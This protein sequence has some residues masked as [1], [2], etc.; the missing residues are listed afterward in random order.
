MSNNVYTPRDT[1]RQSTPLPEE[2]EYILQ[3]ISVND[4]P[5]D[6]LTF[7]PNDPIHSIAPTS[8]VPPDTS[9][10]TPV[11][12]QSNPANPEQFRIDFSLLPA[13]SSI[14]C[15]K[16]TSVPQTMPSTPHPAYQRQQIQQL[17]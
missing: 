16:S 14:A 15:S 2:E 9:T 7:N 17:A 3:D 13:Y 5:N 8:T 10:L 11:S 6:I 12:E 1:K 4:I